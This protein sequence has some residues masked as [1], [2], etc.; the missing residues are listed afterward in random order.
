MRTKKIKIKRNLNRILASKTQKKISIKAIR[1]Q[2]RK[3]NKIINI[4]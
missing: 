1:Y 2:C 3:N 4:K